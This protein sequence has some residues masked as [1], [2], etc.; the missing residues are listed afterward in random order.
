MAAPPTTGVS[1]NNNKIS[2]NLHLFLQLQF[3]LEMRSMKQKKIVFINKMLTRKKTTLYQTT[4]EQARK[5]NPFRASLR[6]SRSIQKLKVVLTYFQPMFDF[7]INQVVDFYYQNVWKTSV[8]EY[9]LHLYLKCHSSA[10]VF[11]TFW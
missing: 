11:Q 6:S 2:V 5:K 1:T 8:E 4:M 9:D 7:C 10:G 3:Y